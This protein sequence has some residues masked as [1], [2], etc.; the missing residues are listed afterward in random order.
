MKSESPE[1]GRPFVVM[2]KPVGRRCNLACE[3]CY[4]TGECDGQGPYDPHQLLMSDELL[5]EFILQYMEASE[6]PEV[7]IVWHGGEPTL[8]GLDFYKRAVEIEKRY[9]PQGWE[10]WNNL[11]TNG[12]LLD[13][14]WAT[15]IAEEHFDVGLSIDGAAW[16]HDK[17]RKN[18]G[19]Q[20]SHKNAVSAIRRLQAHN[21]QPDLLCTVTS[22]AAREPLAVYRA[23]RELNTG[24]IQFIPIVRR[25]A[26]GQLTPD[27]VSAE[28]YGKFLC[29]IFDEWAHHDIGRLDVQLF[30]E[31]ARV[32]A[33][34]DAGLC[35]MTPTCGR[36]LIVEKD[37]GV[38][39][40]DHFVYPEYRIGDIETN[41]LR[42][43]ADLPIQL[44]FGNAKRDRLNTQ[45][46]ACPHLVV[47]N[48]GCP[49]DRFIPGQQ[50]YTVEDE[51]PLNLLCVGLKKFFSH[52]QPIA[53][54][55]MQ[56][57]RH[58]LP[59]ADIM[60]ELRTQAQA[61]WKNV[62]RND[63]CPCGSG[64]KAKHCCWGKKVR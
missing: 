58:G 35:W 30:A 39:S 37:G 10:C 18:Y 6:G 29:A 22:S 48:G 17:Y 54:Q 36:A 59:P 7:H 52:A 15:F 55:I 19:G 47:C 25:D 4:Y 64:L 38:Y 40:C 2:A 61:V 50:V 56:L 3:Y 41:R 32:W 60:A 53:M 23:L 12:V 28:G 63:P 62:G 46:R 42:D 11:Q 27:S 13:E 14:Q 33:G 21:V 43:L 9:L 16:L 5:E 20:G 49:K 24:W 45:C 44:S 1:P 51:P 31:A 57:T 8:A 26:A 34:G